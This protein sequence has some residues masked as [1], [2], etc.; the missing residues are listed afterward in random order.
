[1]A[2]YKKG[3]FPNLKSIF[4][5]VFFLFYIF[6]EKGG[7]ITPALV[8]KRKSDILWYAVTMWV[9]FY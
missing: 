6:G 4:H 1:M 2:P 3:G 9:M 5:S 7:G 8:T